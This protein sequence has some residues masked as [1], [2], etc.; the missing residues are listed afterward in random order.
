MKNVLMLFLLSLMASLQTSS[1]A[2]EELENE[3]LDTLIPVFTVVLIMVALLSC[4]A[5]FF[6]G[7]DWLHDPDQDLGEQLILEQDKLSLI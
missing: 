1:E 5:H 3:V 2:R 4:I 7:Y 6:C